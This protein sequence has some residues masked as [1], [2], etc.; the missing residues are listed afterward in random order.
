MRACRL[1][2]AAALVLTAQRSTSAAELLSSDRPIERVIDHYVDALIKQEKVPTAPMADDATVVRRLMLDLIGRIPT[3]FEVKSYIESKDA[4]KKRQLVDKLIASP[5]FTRHQA[6][7][8]ETMLAPALGNAGG[9]LREYFNRALAENRPWDRIFRDLVTPDEN[10]PKQKGAGEF[11]KGR[12]K[13]T[14]RLTIDVS[15]LFFGVNISCAQCHNHP[16][17]HAWKQDLFYGMKSFFVRTVDSGGFV[18]E[19]EFGQLRYKPNKADEKLAMP[20]FL[21]GESIE[22]PNYREP[23]GAEQKAEKERLDKGK[24]N[25]TQPAPPAVSARS[26][27]VETALKREN[28]EFFDKSIANRIWHRFFGVALVNPMD[29]MHVENPAS[30]PELL[31][32]LARDTANHGYDLRRLIRGI[33]L[34]EPY[35]RSSRF[36]GKEIP[37][38]KYF[39]IA[40]LKPLTP[41]QYATSLKV[42]AADPLAFQQ[43]KP[44]EIEKRMEQIDSSA[45]GFSP[46]LAIPGGDD[47]QIGVSEAL[48]FSN[49]QRVMQEFLNDAGGT[50]LARVAEAKDRP[51]AIDL[52]FCNCLGRSATSDEF[53]MM[54]DYLEKRS[55]RPRAAYQQLV[56]ALIASSEFRF[57][58]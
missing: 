39:A 28:A 35:A 38:S 2:L 49:S 13:D 48:L 20:L 46:L 55:D 17:V 42:A 44:E 14:D 41:M 1:L 7:Q 29:Q 24:A 9:N 30:H 34:S 57:N 25:K 36:M 53:K 50:L 18:G 58:Y 51:T 43:M 54:D 23:T 3:A 45:R 26:I 32:W 16:H 56:W 6:N 22:L 27:L 31:E 21:T 47:F 19:R 10:D 15:T 40:K 4:D 37:D 52:I 12:V 5:A 33:V 8:F 11:L